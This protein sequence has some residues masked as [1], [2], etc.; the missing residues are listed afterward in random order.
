MTK[1]QKKEKALAATAP[2]KSCKTGKSGNRKAGNAPVKPAKKSAPAAP[3]RST[4]LTRPKKD[5]FEGATSVEILSNSIAV[6][7][8]TSKS[9]NGKFTSSEKREYVERTEA[10]IRKLD[11]AMKGSA[12]KKVRIDFAEQ[13]RETKA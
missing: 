1:K 13:K 9:A 5:V 11:A 12:I 3:K 4:Q 2:K 6:T 8:K 10:N 7:R